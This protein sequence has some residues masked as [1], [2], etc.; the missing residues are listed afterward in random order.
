MPLVTVTVC[1]Y[2]AER[3]IEETLE[4][5]LSQTFRDFDILVV[6]DGSTDGTRGVVERL[7][8]RHSRVKY[9]FQSNGGL[10][11]ARN[12]SLRFAEGEWLAVIDHDDICLPDRLQMQ[13]DAARSAPDASLIFSDSEHFT[14]DGRVLRT[15][16]QRF[17]PCALDLS[18]GAA[19]VQLLTHGNFIDSETA[20]FRK[21]AAIIAGGFDARYVYSMDYDFF[22][23]MAA[24]YRLV[25]INRIL[26]RWRIHSRQLTSLVPDKAL[27]ET[28][29]ILSE[30]ENRPEISQ[31]VRSAVRT[32][33]FLI[34][35][36]ALVNRARGSQAGALGGLLASAVRTAPRSPS[37]LRWLAKSLAER[38]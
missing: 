34:A 18:A 35:L 2:N 4:S 37:E 1:A 31:Q 11:S 28:A 14:D 7:A 10:S 30:W 6:D 22:L 20:F 27:S 19:A 33:R 3:Y 5:V 32:R 21:S 16:F 24:R 9:R 15:Q 13:I 36:R 38:L 8:R 23:R 25:G 17:N 29:L 12:A 26:S